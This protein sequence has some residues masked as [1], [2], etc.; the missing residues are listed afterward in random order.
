LKFGDH[1]VISGNLVALTNALGAIGGV[2]SQAPFH[3]LV[4]EIGWRKAYVVIAIIPAIL[5]VAVFF[6]VTDNREGT[7]RSQLPVNPEGPLAVHPKKQVDDKNVPLLG[8]IVDSSDKKFVSKPTLIERYPFLTPLMAFEFWI[9]LVNLGGLDS[10]F[11]SLAGLWGQPYL[12]QAQKLSPTLSSWISTSLV[13]VYSICGVLAGPMCGRVK[14]TAHRML[15]LIAFTAI[16]VA[17]MLGLILF[18]TSADGEFETIP[19]GFIFC[20]FILVGVSGTG[21]AIIWITL[22]DRP[23]TP[24]QGFSNGVA[25][26]VCLG[27]S[28]VVQTIVGVILDASWD[29]AET[30]DGTRE[31]SQSAF[32]KA[33]ALLLASF[34][35]GLFAGIYLFINAKRKSSLEYKSMHI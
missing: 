19:V 11:E 2:A 21:I 16:G 22:V 6:F 1:P 26:G 24:G 28:A 8:H 29:G 15:L 10:P 25:N 4:E 33:W 17:A 31:Y 13:G 23:A 3:H 9:L 35:M 12:H 18:P 5:T 27:F 14:N 34:V 20:C 30:D 7:R 32:R